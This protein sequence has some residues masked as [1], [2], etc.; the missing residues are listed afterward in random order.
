MSALLLR[1]G[2]WCARHGGWVLAAWCAIVA[3][4]AGGVAALGMNLSSSFTITGMESMDGLDVLSE[5][6]PQAAGTSERVLITTDDG[7]ITAH[8]AA[9][10]QFVADAGA[11]SGI[12]HASDPFADST[13]TVSDH[14]AHVLIQVQADNSVGTLTKTNADKA[15]RVAEELQSAASTLEEADSALTV[16]IAGNI[17]FDVGIELSATEGVGIIIAAIVLLLT[18]GSVLAAGVPILTALIGVAVGM[19]GILVAAAFT[20][21]TSVTPVLAVMIGL[22]VGID[23]ALFII[24]RAREYLAKGIAPDEAAGRAVATAGSAVSFAGITVIIALCGLSVAGIPFLTA[25]GISSAFMV[26]MAVC[27]A[28]TAVPATLGLLGQRITPRNGRAERAGRFSR[29]WINTVTHHPVIAILAVVA[30]LGTL[31]VPISGV[32]LA[33]TDSGFQR[34]GTQRRDAYDAIAQAYGDGYNSPIIVLADL[35]QTD[36]PISVVSDLADDLAG[37]DGVADVALATPNQ[38]GSLA[39]IEI[40]PKHSQSS[41]EATALVKDIRS[42]APDFESE[43]GI[44]D[45]MVTGTTAVAIDISTQLNAALL[46]FGIVVVGL[47]LILLMIVFRSIAVPVTATIG[48]VLSLGAGMGAVGAIF[49]W[50]WLADLLAV[51]KVGA[52]ICFL[53]V[54]VMGVLFGLAMDYEVFLVSRM[55][56]EWIRSHDAQRAVIRG[57][58]GSAQVV[59]AAAI[60]MTGV[61]AAFVS[62]QNVYVKPIAV[63]LTVGIF[64]DAFLVRMTLIPALMTLLGP[65][66]W[67]LPGWLDRLLP[68]VDVEGEGLARALEHADWVSEHGVSELR[69]E[70]L[71]VSEGNDVAIDDLSIVLAPGEL[72]LFCSDDTVARAALAAVVSARLRPTEGRVVVG[73]HALPDG[74]SAVQG[75]TSSLRN[76]DDALSPTARIVIV[77]N[78]GTRRWQRI[79]ELHEE[80]RTVLVTGPVDLAVPSDLSFDARAT[81]QREAPTDALQVRTAPTSPGTASPKH[82][83][84]DSDSITTRGQQ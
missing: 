6:L 20:D 38:D 79:R 16:Q 55:R 62:N 12:S 37:L 64:C 71:V 5:R 26:A 29:R 77:D 23:Y 49:G 83:A 30:V 33:I 76:W 72:G 14:G 2:R 11:I 13:N 22:A 27:V 4:L 73:D 43:Y 80:G 58:V 21:I 59:S 67:W 60:I 28:L 50:G 63:A 48:Y 68:V 1:I 35:L 70:R 8:Q 54:I 41:P 81:N 45:L 51:S 42:R 56:E 15:A 36:D 53:P 84:T 78:P 34:E 75:M 10:E 47:S 19:L 7:D 3:L 66:A 46:P 40:I 24:S 44:N 61:F 9:I 32:Y 52:V 39:F 25:M 82:L 69:V 17:G 18:F 65:K 31:T 57:F 74:T